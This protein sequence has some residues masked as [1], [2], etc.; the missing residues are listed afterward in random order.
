MNLI[1]KSEGTPPIV[2]NLVYAFQ[3]MPAIM[4]ATASAP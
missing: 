1:Y 4:A 3:Q 2:E